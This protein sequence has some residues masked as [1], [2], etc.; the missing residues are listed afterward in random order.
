MKQIVFAVL[1]LFFLIIIL[2]K[3]DKKEETPS[4]ETAV[5]QTVESPETV[6]ED[7]DTVIQVDE[8]SEESS[9]EKFAEANPPVDGGR[10]V[11]WLVDEVEKLTPEVP[12]IKVAGASV[13]T[14]CNQLDLDNLPS[15]NAMT[16]AI[17]TGLVKEKKIDGKPTAEHIS[18]AKIQGSL[19]LSVV[20]EACGK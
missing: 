10:E 7:D 1:A 16:F 17:L 19:I 6:V 9:E 12:A 2:D 3:D 20:T 11:T 8:Q 15:M 18:D 5:E 13:I 4:G 14:E